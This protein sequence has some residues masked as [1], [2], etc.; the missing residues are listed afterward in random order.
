MEVRVLQ[1]SKSWDDYIN[2]K[3]EPK[4]GEF[5]KEGFPRYVYDNHGVLVFKLILSNGDIIEKAYVDLSQQYMA[6][7]TQ[8]R[9]GITRNVVYDL[10]V[11]AWKEVA[12]E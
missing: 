7:G 6:D 8:W 3:I 5:Y 1:Q 9:N 10:W 4:K 12:D 2:K 11:I